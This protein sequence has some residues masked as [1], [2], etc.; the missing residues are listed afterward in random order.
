MDIVFSNIKGVH[1]ISKK[2]N[3]HLTESYQELKKLDHTE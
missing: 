3:K 2:K 1:G